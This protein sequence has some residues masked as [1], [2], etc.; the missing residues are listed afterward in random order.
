MD[1]I[2]SIANNS[3]IELQAYAN[4]Q[5]EAL[6]DALKTIRKLENEVRHLKQILATTPL[7]NGE[8]TPL[9]VS[10][11]QII[12][13]MEIQRLKEVSFKRGLTLEETK[14]FDLCVKNLQL[15]KDGNKDV[16]VPFK[17]LNGLSHE[18][19]LEIASQPENIE[20]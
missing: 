16:V 5:Y 9:I 18:A 10:D 14:R 17:N 8:P 13:E 11:G 20:E 2:N 7:T 1:T 4:A 3:A 6:Q 12:C 19:L 15:I